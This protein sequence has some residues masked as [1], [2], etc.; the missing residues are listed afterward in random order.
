MHENYYTTVIRHK[1]LPFETKLYVNNE[2][3][4]I[5][6]LEKSKQAESISRYEASDKSLAQEI[7]ETSQKVEICVHT[8]WKVLIIH[9]F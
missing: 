5:G 6:L 4:K 9:M 1:T 2:S 3:S 8:L 7:R